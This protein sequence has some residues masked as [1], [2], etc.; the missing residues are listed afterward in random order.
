MQS[1]GIIRLAALMFSLAV[2]AIIIAT[3]Y[4]LWTTK[5]PILLLALYR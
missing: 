2:W 5:M 1:V 3:S 4:H